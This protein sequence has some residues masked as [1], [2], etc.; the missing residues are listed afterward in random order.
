MR[1]NCAVAAWI[2]VGSVIIQG[3]SMWHVGCNSMG[4]W[5]TQAEPA[6]RR[7]SAK[8][9]DVSNPQPS[10]LCRFTGV[11]GCVRSMRRSLRLPRPHGCGECVVTVCDCVVTVLHEACKRKRGLADGA[12]ADQPCG[13][14][15]V[16]DHGVAVCGVVVS[17]MVPEIY[18]WNG[19]YHRAGLVRDAR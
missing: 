7:A 13:R 14:L 19:R 2:Q 3:F 15:G 1:N 17:M 8:P 10:R 6:R 5:K 11:I 16:D 9:N 12:E 4:V 18:A